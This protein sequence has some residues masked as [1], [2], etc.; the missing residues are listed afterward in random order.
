MLRQSH[1]HRGSRQ[2]SREVFYRSTRRFITVVH[3]DGSLR[4]FTT[5]VQMSRVVLV[6]GGTRGIGHAVAAALL[7]AGDK[8]AITGTTSDGV[9]KAE[10]ALTTSG[11]Y[12][13]GI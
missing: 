6:T 13:A 4:G 5:R 9:L 7:K 3:H 2:Y 8:V 10:R 11:M 1:R 12:I